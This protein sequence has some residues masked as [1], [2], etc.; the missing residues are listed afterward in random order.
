MLKEPKFKQELHDF[1]NFVI[2]DSISQIIIE[3]SGNIEQNKIKSFKEELC[4][5]FIKSVTQKQ[6][7]NQFKSKYSEIIQST[8]FINE[9][10]EEYIVET[11]SLFRLRLLNILKN[12]KQA[13]LSQSIEDFVIISYLDKFV[14]SNVVKILLYSSRI[15]FAEVN[16]F[17]IHLIEIF[18]EVLDGTSSLKDLTEYLESELNSMALDILIRDFI[19]A[20]IIGYLTTITRFENYSEI[21]VQ[22]KNRI[23]NKITIL[24][25]TS[26]IQKHRIDNI[27]QWL[28]QEVIS[29]FFNMIQ[30]SNVEIIP[31][32]EV[33][34][35]SIREMY[36]K[37]LERKFNLE[38][39]TQKLSALK[40]SIHLS[41]KN[42]SGNRFRFAKN[43]YVSNKFRILRSS[44][45]K[46]IDGKPEKIF[47]LK[48][49]L[50]DSNDLTP[51]KVIEM[52]FQI[53]MYLSAFLDG[54]LSFDYQLDNFYNLIKQNRDGT[55]Q[56]YL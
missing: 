25:D 38:M 7:H 34:I 50:S 15:S 1:F 37:Q 29:P 52:E 54:E 30:G 4:K 11:I 48:D 26:F 28:T 3:S 35:S 44:N 53:L 36:R 45:P 18:R 33:I 24:S 32:T 49:D 19:S 20:S 16:E 14:L 6:S 51:E 41:Y 12:E 17:R 39:V 8:G 22:M 40:E 23:K 31:E 27:L 46:N 47:N 42:R 5:L 55:N 13:E 9:L 10:M 43:H 2:W 21:I 56:I